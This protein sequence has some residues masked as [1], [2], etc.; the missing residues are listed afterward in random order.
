[1]RLAGPRCDNHALRAAR[2]RDRLALRVR[3]CR[4]G[5]LWPARR[6]G[7]R[8]RGHGRRH[9][10][11]WHVAAPRKVIHRPAAGRIRLR[12]PASPLSRAGLGA[13]G[14]GGHSD[15]APSRMRNA[16]SPSDVARARAA[17]AGGGGGWAPFAGVKGGGVSRIPPAL[18]AQSAVSDSPFFHRTRQTRV[19]L[20]LNFGQ[21]PAGG[22]LGSRK[23]IP[24]PPAEKPDRR[25]E[26]WDFVGL[27]R[28]RLRNNC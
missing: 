5:P 9:R 22:S 18:A 1:M 28:Y 26:N 19:T 4:A 13:R 17:G 3:P 23:R 24:E 25:D 7:C 16:T 15:R 12:R 6:P 20:N 27:I 21:T 8:G 10:R 14:P 2:R 11:L